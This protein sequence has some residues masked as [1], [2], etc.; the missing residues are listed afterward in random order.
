MCDT[1]Y[2]RK[3]REL[4]YTLLYYCNTALAETFVHV[5]FLKNTTANTHIYICTFPI[6]KLFC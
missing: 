2:V 4:N 5:P 6:R 1:K 3:K